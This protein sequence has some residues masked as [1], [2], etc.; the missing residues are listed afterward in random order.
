MG[1]NIIKDS[2]GIPHIVFNQ[3]ITK[4]NSYIGNTI[5]D[6]EIL[7]VL[8]EGSYGYVAKAKSK[9]NNTIYAIKQMKL[10][11]IAQK[12]IRDLIENEIQ[13]LQKLKNPFITKYY[14]SFKS[15]EGNIYIVMEYMNNG[16]LAKL[17][18]SHMII[19]KPIEEERLW[20]IFIQA[21]KSLEFIHSN[22]I[23]HRDI[24]PENLFMNNSGIVKLG[25]F[26]F[27]A[28]YKN[29]NNNGMNISL[30]N[31]KPQNNV[32]KID[33]KGTVIGTENFMSPEMVNK[34]QYD[35][36]TDVYSMGCTFF[37]AMFWT[38]PKIQNRNFNQ[39]FF[40]NNNMNN[41]DINS[42]N[43][44]IIYNKDY[45]SKELVNLVY[46]MIEKNKNKRPDSKSILNLFIKEY[47][48]KYSKNS[49]IGSVLSCLYSCSDL[50]NYFKNQD[51]TFQ[52]YLINKNIS[53]EFLSG[54]NSRNNQE[55]WKSFLFKIR[56]IIS[57]QNSLYEKD[58]EIDPRFFLSYFLKRLHHELNNKNDFFSNPFST[59]FTGKQNNISNNNN[60][61][62][63]NN[64][65]SNMINFSKKEDSFK[66]FCKY[67]KENN[68]SIIS[69]S[70]YGNMKTKTVC[71]SCL[72]TTY[73]F[74]FFNFITFN[75]DSIQ[76]YIISHNYQN[77]TLLS[78]SDCFTIQNSLLIKIKNFSKICRNC[79]NIKHSERK[80][81][82][83]FPKY[84]IVCLDRGMNCQNKLSVKYQAT[85]DLKKNC[86]N[87]DSYNFFR[88]I[89][90]IKRLDINNIEHYI[91]LYFDCEMNSW[92]LRDDNCFKQINSPLEHTQGNEI[93]FFYEGIIQYNN[94]G[95]NNVNT[96][97][98]LSMDNS[99]NINS[100]L[101]VKNLNNNNNTRNNFNNMNMNNNMNNNNVIRR[102]SDNIM[103]NNF[104][105]N[106]NNNNKNM[107]NMNFISDKSMNRYMN[108]NINTNSISFNNVNHNSNNNNKFQ[109]CF[110]YNNF[111]NMNGNNNFN[112]MNY[113]MNQN[114]NN[115]NQNNI[116]MN[117]TN[118]KMEIT[119]N[120]NN[121]MNISGN[122]L[123]NNN[124]NGMNAPNINIFNLN[125]NINNNFNN[126]PNGVAYNNYMK[127]EYN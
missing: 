75:L 55:N 124:N 59:L 98:R 69:N 52:N 2:K 14:K 120:L 85:L 71:E 74:N 47:I 92:I 109:R 82:C 68:N 91:S 46:K 18:K 107:N 112:N 117:N 89:G 66:F 83:T 45:Y 110:T 13:I 78:I 31:M 56:L 57:Q 42:S 76:K 88:L 16:D 114:N 122:N 108:L 126:A 51:M 86:E 50:L 30:E 103:N 60:N 36:K 70:F 111:N 54:L 80:Q 34:C 15:N 5:D 11:I 1:V 38:T 43:D 25:D 3:K 10:N 58:I 97:A 123:N 20:N 67:F 104:I 53:I 49:G 48:K 63:Q 6:F 102:N 84:L 121:K 127:T 90:V 116:F 79:K 72:L 106:L 26:G 8:G 61:N 99:K 24:K 7:Q 115:M 27:S 35:L 9:K 4:N 64:L 33:C 65:N 93:M 100:M 41:M 40:G 17:I 32:A 105:N 39:M 77:Q 19:N 29:N 101:Q 118:N 94:V 119:N 81:F 12:N 44:Q 113:N 95:N 125:M 21:L 96:L 73:T 23:I 87:V 37:Q 22:Q 28:N 62:M